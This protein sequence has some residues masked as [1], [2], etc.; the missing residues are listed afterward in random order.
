MSDSL[1]ST[2]VKHSIIFG[3]F[4]AIKEIICASGKNKGSTIPKA[5]KVGKVYFFAPFLITLHNFLNFDFFSILSF[6][7]L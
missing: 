4:F 3:K 1:F 5:F 7:L 2:P 6:D